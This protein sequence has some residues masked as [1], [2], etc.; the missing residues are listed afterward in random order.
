MIYI[1]IV[2]GKNFS[3]F[4]ALFYH[5][6]HSEVKQLIFTAKTPKSQR[7]TTNYI[8]NVV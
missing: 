8:Y 7:K 4:P 1:I 6:E 3:A 5:R 2:K